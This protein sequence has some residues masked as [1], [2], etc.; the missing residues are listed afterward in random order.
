MNLQPRPRLLFCPAW[1]PNR[2][3]ETSGLF[4]LVLA[5]E[6]SAAFDLK[7]LYVHPHTDRSLGTVLD[8]EIEGSLKLLRAY[9]FRSAA[10]G[11][12]RHLLY[13]RTFMKAFEQLYPEDE[14][15]DLIF[16]RG[17]LPGGLGAHSLH[18]RYGIPYLTLD[19]F[20]GLEEQMRSPAKRWWVRRVLRSAIRN[21][22]VSSSHVRTLGKIF[23]EVPFEVRTNVVAV[24]DPKPGEPGDPDEQLKILYAGGVVPIKGWDILLDALRLYID[25]GAAPPQLTM[26]GAG[27]RSD[28]DARVEALGLRDAV[29]FLGI[30]PHDE[31]KTLIRNHHFLVL[32]SRRDT[33]PNVVLETFMEGR[34]VLAT[35][36]GGAE[37][38]VNATT[39]HLVDRESPEALAE[40][41]RYM[42]AHLSGFPSEGIRYYVIENHSIGS[43]V[44]FLS[45][46]LDA[47]AGSA[48]AGDKSSYAPNRRNPA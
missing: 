2:F 13:V 41:I 19:S 35:R 36:S 48:R 47:G 43:L 12:L 26:L 15:P 20:S 10:I 34:P 7:V 39:G 28:L 46:T 8:E 6:L 27:E 38:M 14:R 24:A 44:R 22:G 9:P 29:T 18:R 45:E 21:A 32:P 1:F 30:V 37:D 23:P 5:R 42:K 16:V 17:L 3:H 40:G 25:S 11:P 33:C 4:N 31:V